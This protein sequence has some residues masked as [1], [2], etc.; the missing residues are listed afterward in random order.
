MTSLSFSAAHPNHRELLR[1]HVSRKA[2][3]KGKAVLEGVGL[4]SAAIEA[5][6]WNN[7]RD[8]VEAV[9]SGLI[10]WSKGYQCKQPTWEVLL[11]A[12]THAQIAEEH[13]EGLKTD[14][15]LH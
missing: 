5:H 7:P 3:G 9:Q 2:V 14:L 4:N 10:E 1:R 15:G 12:M 13:I 11:G 6:F 8:V